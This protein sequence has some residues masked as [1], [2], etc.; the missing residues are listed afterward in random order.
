M[1]KLRLR[2]KASCIVHGKLDSN[3]VLTF[4]LQQEPWL[5]DRNYKQILIHYQK[6]PF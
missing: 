5:M 3:P 4:P 1:G 6:E 2:D